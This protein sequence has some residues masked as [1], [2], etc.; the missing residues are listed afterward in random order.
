MAASG[1]R[2]KQNVSCLFR[3][4]WQKLISNI[5]V[6]VS[7]HFSL[8]TSLSNWCQCYQTFFHHKKLGR[9]S[10]ATN[11]IRFQYL[12]TREETRTRVGASTF[13]TTTLSKMKLSTMNVIVTLSIK[14]TQHSCS[15]HK[16]CISL[17]WMSSF[18]CRMYHSAC[19]HSESYYA[20]YYY[21]ECL[22]VRCHDTYCRAL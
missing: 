4:K 16:Y 10:V 7:G 18:L 1:Q 20:E 3:L 21:A 9:L 22:N 8:V 19:H 12:Q 13:S 5:V 15:Q 2:K 14:E 17:C 6:A 11:F